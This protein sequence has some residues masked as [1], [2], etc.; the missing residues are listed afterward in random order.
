MK[1]HSLKI[2]RKV[3][4][5]YIMQ[6]I[7]E[8]LVIHYLGGKIEESKESRFII[9]SSFAALEGSLQIAAAFALPHFPHVLINYNKI[10]L[11]FNLKYIVTWK[12][13]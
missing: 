13:F 5:L 10:I 4:N 2:V 11:L 6:Q 12:T 7:W 3:R 9:T 8:K 1:T